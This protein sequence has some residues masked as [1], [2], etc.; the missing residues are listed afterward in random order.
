MKNRYE[1]TI[2]TVVEIVAE[3]GNE[4][5]DLAEEYVM[6]T[7]VEANHYKVEVLERDIED[8]EEEF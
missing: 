2:C 8:E 7:G 3:D 4:A 1:V 6:K 5:I